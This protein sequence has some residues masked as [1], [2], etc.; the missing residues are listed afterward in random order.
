MGIPPGTWRSGYMGASGSDGFS[1]PFIHVA[2]C[3]RL[4]EAQRCR[5]SLSVSS[6]NLTPIPK[7]EPCC[8]SLLHMSPHLLSWVAYQAIHRWM[9]TIMDSI[10]DGKVWRTIHCKE[11][12][13]CAG[14][15]PRSPG[16]AF[17]FSDTEIEVEWHKMH[18]T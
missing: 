12:W 10:C 17:S 13:L 18:F 11:K 3:G 9:P 4:T 6:P 7:R 8:P 15:D 5:E 14:K 2:E 1:C 16:L